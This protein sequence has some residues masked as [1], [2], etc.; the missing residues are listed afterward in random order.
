MGRFI[1]QTWSLM[2]LSNVTGY[3]FLCHHHVSCFFCCQICK[4]VIELEV[5]ESWF[6]FSLSGG[7]K[8]VHWFSF[9]SFR[10]WKSYFPILARLAFPT[11]SN[12]TNASVKCIHKWKK[13]R[14]LMVSTSAL[15][16]GSQTQDEAFQ[17]N[18]IHGVTQTGLLPCQ[19][20]HVEMRW[21]H[22]THK[23]K[24]V[25]FCANFLGGESGWIHK[26]GNWV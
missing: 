5:A 8:A 11:W 22:S 7:K 24:I 3:Y 19:R 23:S 16:Q 12:K 4:R 14:C 26:I 9:E 18:R 2:H 21:V 17:Y 25:S 15:I 13:S 20:R 10:T 6:S 1:W